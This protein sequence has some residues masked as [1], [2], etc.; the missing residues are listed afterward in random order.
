MVR[1]YVG[2]AIVLAAAC[3]VLVGAPTANAAASGRPAAATPSA[4]ERRRRWDVLKSVSRVRETECTCITLLLDRSSEEAAPGE[5]RWR[6]PN[7]RTPCLLA[8]I[9]GRSLGIKENASNA[10]RSQGPLRQT[11][12]RRQAARRTAAMTLSCRSARHTTWSGSQGLA[13][14]YTS[15]EPSARVALRPAA[16]A[17]PTGAAESHSY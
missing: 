16:I 7:P 9:P 2:E 13:R 1:T 12:E 6:P 11:T 14:L 8:M 15:C 5:A 4:R 17:T 10:S 3:T